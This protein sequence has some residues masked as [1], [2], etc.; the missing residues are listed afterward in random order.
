[1]LPVAAVTPCVISWAA[2]SMEVSGLALP[3][4]SPYVMQ[5]QASDQKALT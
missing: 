3:V 4:P 1:M 5:K 2:T